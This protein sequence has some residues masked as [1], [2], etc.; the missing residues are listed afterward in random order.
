MNNGTEKIELAMQDLDRLAA[1]PPHEA[2]ITH[3]RLGEGIRCAWPV[4]GSI[5]YTAHRKPWD[6][7][8]I[9][10]LSRFMPP[11]GEVFRR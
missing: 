4:A 8:N 6:W 3:R 5:S 11:N 2:I 10:R 1:T 7:H 9:A